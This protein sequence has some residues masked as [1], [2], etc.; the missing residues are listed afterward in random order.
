MSSADMTE[1]IF[2]LHPYGK[3]ALKK[4]GIVPENFRLYFAGWIGKYPDFHGMEV[5]GAEFRPALAGRNKGK[6]CI[7]IKDS[8]RTA[9]VSKAEIEAE[10]EP[11]QPKG[12]E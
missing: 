3:A 1:K 11:E 10:V 7:K 8:D 12:G 6:L 9:Y 4:M 5:K 2:E